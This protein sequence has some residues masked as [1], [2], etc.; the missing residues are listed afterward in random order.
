MASRLKSQCQQTDQ[1]CAALL[2][3]LKQRGLLDDTL[4]VW[5]GE[6]GRTPMVEASAALGR[7]QGRDHH[8]QAFTMW[9]AGGGVKAGQTIGGTDELGF[10]PVER[11]VH[12]ADVQ[13]TMLKLLGIDHARLTYRVGGL[14]FRLTGVEERHFIDELIA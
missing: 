11:P 2:Q 5:G 7:S 8:P 13:A 3:D 10:H 6:F 14:D 9:F 1:A 12:I 4:V